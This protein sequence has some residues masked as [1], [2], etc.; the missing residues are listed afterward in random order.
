MIGAM[1]SGMLTKGTHVRIWFDTGAMGAQWLFG[2]IIHAGQRTFTVEWESTI[3]NRFRQ[4]DHAELEVVSQA[5]YEEC[6]PVYRRL[7]VR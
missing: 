6:V 4:D 7:E 2:T 3:R 5:L 1:I